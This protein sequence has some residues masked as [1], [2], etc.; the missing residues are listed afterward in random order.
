M[1]IGVFLV[2]LCNTSMQ[3]LWRPKE[4]DR[5]SGAAVS[6]GCDPPY[7]VGAGTCTPGPLQGQPV[8]LTTQPSF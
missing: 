2:C 4:G 8:L 1:C 7:D 5:C 6:G 3:Y